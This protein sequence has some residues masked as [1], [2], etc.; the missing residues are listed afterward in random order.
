MIRR[1]FLF[2]VLFAIGGSVIATVSMGFWL[3]A[4]IAAA[5]VVILFGFM[6]R[7]LERDNRR[8]QRIR[9]SKFTTRDSAKGKDEKIR[10]AV[11]KEW[12]RKSTFDKPEDL[13]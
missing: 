4:L 9:G 8:I 7:Y 10:D 13:R 5:A 12:D 2:F 3:K 11:E 6:M 1:S